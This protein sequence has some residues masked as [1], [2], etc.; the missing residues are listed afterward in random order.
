MKILLETETMGCENTTIGDLCFI[1]KDIKK[2]ETSHGKPTG[3]Y[4]FHTGA[5]TLK[6][7]VDTYDVDHYAVI[8]NKT[9]GSGKCNVALDKNFSCAKQAFVY[10]SKVKDEVITKFVFYYVTAMLS[11]MEEGYVGPCH[12]NISRDYIQNFAIPSMEYDNLVEIV[13]KCDEISN[14]IQ[15]FYQH[16]T[17]VEMQKQKLINS[18]TKE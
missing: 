15:D 10:Y 11:K 16:I 7:Y 12:K 5:A 8:Q 1:D 3:V 2:H 6:T 18:H 14:N 9:N 13:H 17:N 4:K